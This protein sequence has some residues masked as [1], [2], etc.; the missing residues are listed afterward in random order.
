M[1]LADSAAAARP[2]DSGRSARCAPRCA[3]RSTRRLGKFLGNFAQKLRRAFFGFRRD[4]FFHETLHPREFFVNSLPK[5]FE[6]VDALN[7]REFFVN[8][9]AKLLEFVHGWGVLGKYAALRR[10]AATSVL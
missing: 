6:V 1:K 9:F 10:T 4:L 8:A 5:V 7:A 3:L 2:V